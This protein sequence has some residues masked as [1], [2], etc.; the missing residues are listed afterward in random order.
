MLCLFLLIDIILGLD[1]LKKTQVN[2]NN[3]LLVFCVLIKGYGVH[4]GWPDIIPGCSGACL[5]Q[6]T[7]LHCWE[8][9]PGR[10]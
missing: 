3:D 2:N 6:C 10:G 4:L 8:R 5:P 1:H 7:P 9:G